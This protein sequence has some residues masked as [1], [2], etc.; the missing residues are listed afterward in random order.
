MST[1]I[2]DGTN[3][4]S[5]S[6]GDIGD[7]NRPVVGNNNSLQWQDKGLQ[8]WVYNLGASTMVGS[9]N[10]D[11]INNNAIEV[12]VNSIFLNDVVGDSSVD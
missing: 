3:N 7:E 1:N 6:N 9:N 12:D 10:D 8:R 11:R 4:A 5:G 2:S